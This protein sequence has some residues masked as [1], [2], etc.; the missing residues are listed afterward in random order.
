MIQQMPG[1]RSFL[2]LL[3][4]W[5]VFPVK[6][7][8]KV[9]KASPDT[10]VIYE[11]QIVYDTLY[12]YDTIRVP[13]QGKNIPAQ[14]KEYDN[15]IL[16]ITAFPYDTTLMAD[17]ALHGQL[18]DKSFV[19]PYPHKPLVSI[20]LTSL[21]NKYLNQSEKFFCEL[22]ATHFEKGIINAKSKMK[23]MKS[24]RNNSIYADRSG[25]GISAGGGGWQA[26]SFDG[27]LRS[28]MLLS[29]H[30]GIFYEKTVTRHIVC[31][32]ALHYTWTLNKGIHFHHDD[33]MD[34]IQSSSLAVITYDDIFSWD[35]D[36][37]KDARFSFSQIDI[38]VKVGYQISF[39]RPYL[40]FKY[41]RRFKHN[42]LHKG[43]YFSALI[44]AEILL[45]NRLSLGINYSYGLCEEIQ[46]NG[47][48]NGT[49]VGNIVVMPDS[50]VV[51]SSYPAEEHVNNNAGA[52]SGQ[53]ID[54]SLYFSLHGN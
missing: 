13:K 16:G 38:P 34:S 50:K 40:G 41:T 32:V 43:N 27:N 20:P 51:I 33:F 8:D 7:Q 30:A 54:F 31:K 42:Q 48:I 4:I 53:R 19:T 25:W 46:R 12:I 2:F 29:P 52:L 49:T 3:L 11:T 6:S 9:K 28:D 36:G 22:P 35:V 5:V 21:S 10:L 1:K 17:T 44:G 24:E 14:T 45:S 39:L 37:E 23:L 18:M 15:T 47:Q 26:R